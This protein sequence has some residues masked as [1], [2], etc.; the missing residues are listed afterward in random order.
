MVDVYGSEILLRL[1]VLVI[2][3]AVIFA[4]VGRFRE[5]AI[6]EGSKEIARAESEE[7]L[8]CCFDC[9]WYFERVEL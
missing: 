7:S 2:T 6:L 5:E 9:F 1:L 4:A 3:V 8:S